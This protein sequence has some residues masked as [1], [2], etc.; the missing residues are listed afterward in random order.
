MGASLGVFDGSEGESVHTLRLGGEWR[1]DEAASK[2]A[3]EGS[4]VHH[5]I[6]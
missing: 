6:T 5:S 4:S 2:R 1:G 3:D